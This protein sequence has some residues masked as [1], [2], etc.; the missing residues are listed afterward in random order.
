MFKTCTLKF[1]RL[2]DHIIICLQRVIRKKG[3]HFFQSPKFSNVKKGA[4]F[5]QSRKFSNVKKGAHFFLAPNLF[6]ISS[7]QINI[8]LD[9]NGY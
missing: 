9:K 8:A 6:R 7:C 1:Q 4:H 3:A 5:F 2:I